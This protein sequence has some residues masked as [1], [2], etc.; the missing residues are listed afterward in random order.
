M[1]Y[2]SE[3]TQEISFPLGG[4]G[5]GCIGLDGG[6]R[7][8]D[9]EIFNRPSKGSVNRYTHFAIKAIRNGKPITYMLQSDYTKNYVGPFIPN[10]IHRYGHGVDAALMCGPLPGADLYSRYCSTP[11]G[12]SSCRAWHQKHKYDRHS[13]SATTRDEFGNIHDA[14]PR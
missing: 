9:W 2:Q 4:I 12:R 11:F 7:L 6:G 8:I 10:K 5:T 1:R 3:H 13:S 14:D